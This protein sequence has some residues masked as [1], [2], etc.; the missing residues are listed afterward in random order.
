M[1][2]TERGERKWILPQWRLCVLWLYLWWLVYTKTEINNKMS[3][4]RDRI[5]QNIKKKRSFACVSLHG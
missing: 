3:K 2:R 4:R 5:R 1:D